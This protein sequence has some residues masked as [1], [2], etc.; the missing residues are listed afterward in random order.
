[1]N[2][3]LRAH[4]FVIALFVALFFLSLYF[5]K[6]IQIIYD[7]E[8]L[9]PQGDPDLEFYNDFKTQFE[10]DDNNYII[11]IEE[12]NGFFKQEKLKAFQ[13]LQ[14]SLIAHPLILEGISPTSIKLPVKSPFGYLTV[15]SIHI[16]EPERYEQDSIKMMQDP[17]LNGRLVAQ[18]GKS[19]LMILKT[20]YPISQDSAEILHD[21][22]VETLEKSPFENYHTIGRATIQTEFVRF[23]LREML[24]YTSL[25]LVIVLIVLWLVFRKPVPVII[26]VL[27][28]GVALVIFLGSLGYFGIR[29]DFISAL[30]PILMLIVGMSDVIHILSKYIDELKLGMQKELALK[31]TISEIGM[32]T[33][34][35]SVTT[36][37]GFLSLLSSKIEPIRHFGLT[38]A[39]G[40]FLAYIVSILLLPAALMLFDSK[41]I[42]SKKNIL[43]KLDP[44]LN[45]IHKQCKS[46]GTKIMGAALVLILVFIYGTSNINPQG[47]L[48]NDLPQD[49]KI[50]FDYEYFEEIFGGFRPFEIALMPKEGYSFRDIEVLN[51]V[52]KLEEHLRKDTTFHSIFSPN[53]IFR[54]IQRAR[55]SNKIEAY[56]IPENQKALDISLRELEKAPENSFNRILTND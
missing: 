29:M 1:M 32:A 43:G 36:S 37:I 25:A 18:E 30:F 54:G 12:K 45:A 11:G 33:F 23:Q 21:F 19:F 44:L 5:S 38:A 49:Q 2:L 3:F 20:I 27:I 8:S 39:Y 4:K 7:F 6:D 28:V 22:V 53:D 56:E 40:V 31:K 26:S 55:K 48:K 35:T 46:G 9:F 15:P 13:Q 41:A 42:I 17:L 47:K 14:D 24:L 16:N 51:E 50:T 10:P 52:E 34:L